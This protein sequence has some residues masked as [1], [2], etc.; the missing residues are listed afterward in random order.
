[1]LLTIKPPFSVDKFDSLKKEGYYML[2]LQCGFIIG[3]SNFKNY[4]IS[5]QHLFGYHNKVFILERMQFPSKVKIERLT[6]TPRKYHN[7]IISGKYKID[8]NILTIKNIDVDLTKFNESLRQGFESK[9]I[10]KDSYKEYLPPILLEYGYKNIKVHMSNILI[11][12]IIFNNF[13]YK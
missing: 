8:G 13:D 10:N 4:D 1:M 7:I 6:G 11:D 9:P 5:V 3:K 2:K 12:S